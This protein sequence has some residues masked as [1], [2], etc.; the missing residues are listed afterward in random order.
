MLPS[1]RPHDVTHGQKDSQTSCSLSCSHNTIKTF[2]RRHRPERRTWANDSS[3]SC[4][5]GDSRLDSRLDSRSKDLWAILIFVVP[6]TFAPLPSFSSPTKAPRMYETQFSTKQ[7]LTSIHLF[8]VEQQLLK[9]LHCQVDSTA[10]CL[11]D[12]RASRRPLVHTPQLTTGPSAQLLFTPVQTTPSTSQI[13]ISIFYRLSGLHKKPIG[14][15]LSHS[16]VSVYLCVC[17]TPN[18]NCALVQLTTHR[19]TLFKSEQ[20]SSNIIWLNFEFWIRLVTMHRSFRRLLYF[21]YVY[22]V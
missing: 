3:S 7:H 13:Q 2:K 8:W 9:K 14:P 15:L 6:R 5:F 1:E 11:W 17:D 18:S 19:S 12:P 10:E 16:L 22:E 20:R 21:V 4:I